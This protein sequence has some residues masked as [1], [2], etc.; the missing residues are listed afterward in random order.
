MKPVINS[1][2]S[3][4]SLHDCTC[5]SDNLHHAQSAHP[6][7]ILTNVSLTESPRRPDPEHQAAA[8]SRPAAAA[9]RLRVGHR[10]PPGR[11]K[12]NAI[13]FQDLWMMT[14]T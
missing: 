4:I 2:A 3:E 7:Q 14:Q 1:K 8:K 10:A 12:L 11:I 13:I 5:T 9:P 6:N